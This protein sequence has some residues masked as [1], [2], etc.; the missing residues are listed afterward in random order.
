MAG[1]SSARLSDVLVALYM[2]HNGQ[3]NSSNGWFV[4]GIFGFDP[5]A[6]G[7][8]TEGSK[9]HLFQ[10]GLLPLRAA[11]DYGKQQGGC[12]GLQQAMRAQ[13]FAAASGDQ[14]PYGRLMLAAASIAQEYTF[15]MKMVFYDITK[16]NVR[17]FFL[18]VVSHKNLLACSHALAVLCLSDTTCLEITFSNFALRPVRPGFVVLTAHIRPLL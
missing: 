5:C 7:T 9:I 2:I 1:H 10:V 3:T 11:L 13:E 16:D 15:A 6:Q 12:P 17:D 18:S 8:F 4:P 14:V